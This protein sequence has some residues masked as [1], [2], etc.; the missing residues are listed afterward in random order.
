MWLLSHSPGSLLSCIYFCF[1]TDLLPGL[2]SH[3]WTKY[4]ETSSYI[5][6]SKGKQVPLEFPKKTLQALIVST[7]PR[8]YSTMSP[9]VKTWKGKTVIHSFFF[10]FSPPPTVFF[11]NITGHS[12]LLR[13]VKSAFN[14][15]DKELIVQ[16]LSSDKIHFVEYWLLDPLIIFYLLNWIRQLTSKNRDKKLS[17]YL[18]QVFFSLV[19]II[20]KQ[21]ICCA[22]K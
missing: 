21:N 6:K 11:Q 3:I 1:S 13:K 10:F 7:Q 12:N 17:V 20:W 16:S 9:S 2:P 8:K 18:K 4:L 14:F 22:M 5:P 19:T 15:L